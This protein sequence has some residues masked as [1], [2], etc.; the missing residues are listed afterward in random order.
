MARGSALGSATSQ[1]FF[2]LQDNAPLDGNYVVFGE[3]VGDAGLA[4]IDLLGGVPVFDASVQLGPAFG[5][6]PLTS[7]SLDP[8]SLVIVSSVTIVSG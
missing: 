5:E 2:N 4:A 1:F 7:P 8:G 6:L 3:V